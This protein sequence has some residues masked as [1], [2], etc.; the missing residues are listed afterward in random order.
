M[1]LFEL[2]MIIKTKESIVVIFSKRKEQKTCRRG[3]CN[4]VHLLSRIPA[5]RTVG[6]RRSKKQSRSTPRGLR[7]DTDLVEFRKLQEV[8]IFSYLR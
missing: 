4:E 8:E 6:F 5:D 1:V 7:V 2:L 3:R